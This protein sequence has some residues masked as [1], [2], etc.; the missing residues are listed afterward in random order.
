M[1]SLE[2]DKVPEERNAIYSSTPASPIPSPDTFLARLRARTRPLAFAVICGS[3]TLDSFNVTGL[4]YGQLNIADHFNVIVTTASWS[5]SAYSLAF[6]SL[7]LLAGRAGDMYGHKKVYSFG[8]IFFSLFALLAA[9]IDSSFVALCIFRAIQGASAACTVPTAY[10]MV[11]V[12]YQG[13]AREMAVAGL[14]VSS[15]TGAIVGSIVGGAFASTHLGY[16]GVLWLSFG[17]S[18]VLCVL[19]FL[20]LEPTPQEVFS[21]KRPL[22]IIGAF[23][24]TSSLAILVYGF[25]EAPTGWSQAK[26]IAPIVIGITLLFFFMVFEQFIVWKFL[27]QVDP[28][29]PRRVWTYSNLV[30]LTIET[31]FLFACFYLTVL[32]GSTFLLRVQERKPLIS[33]VMWSPL[34]VGTLIFCILMGPFYNH[35]YMPP[36]WLL[37]F[38]PLILATG[39]VLFSRNNTKTGYWQYTFSGSVV[40]SLGTAIFFMHY[41]NVAY[42]AT[43]PEDQGLVSGILQTSAQVATAL[44]LAIGSSFLSSN[45][46]KD[47]LPEY[48][49]SFYVAIAF[50]CAGAIVALLWVTPIPPR[51]SSKKE[52]VE[53]LQ[54]TSSSRVDSVSNVGRETEIKPVT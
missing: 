46:P 39:V 44:G 38:A 35:R 41:L 32:N 21:E 13:K 25:T 6:G 45:T 47:L 18:T 48:K 17:I 37:V 8:L 42:A 7:L 43:P 51:P 1:S 40:M 31:G 33:A 49:N 54:S 11:G 27:P 26:V 15:T 24:V 12:K 36:K 28:L 23:L 10:A 29:I 2:T 53:M 3:L 19:A 5:L 4:I 50:G 34:I 16:R 22:D 14:G 9:S 52:D 30:P 20:L